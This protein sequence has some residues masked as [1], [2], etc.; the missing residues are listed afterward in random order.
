MS[1]FS[2]LLVQAT[3]TVS[4]FLLQYLLKF[5]MKYLKDTLLYIKDSF[6]SEVFIWK[7]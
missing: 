1:L 4:L 2:A 6:N 3:E 7:T 5:W